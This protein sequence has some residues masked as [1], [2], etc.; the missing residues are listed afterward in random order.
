MVRDGTGSKAEVEGYGVGGKTG[1]AEKIGAN[2]RYDKKKLLSSF[3]GVFP[4]DDPE[5]L[6]FVMVD[7]PVGNKQSWG[8]A[9]AG[10]TAA[11]AVA[12]I[13][14]KMTRIL[15]MP[16]TYTRERDMAFV[17][18]VEKLVRKPEKEEREKVASY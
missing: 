15:G 14:T 16:A 9:T 17:G 3:V 4:V 5:Y 7:E 2:G 11:P 6:V 8:Y 12:E 18:E 1:T 10:W 13:I